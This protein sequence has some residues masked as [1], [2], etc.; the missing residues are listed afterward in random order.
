MFEEDRLLLGIR[1]LDVRMRIKKPLA[2]ILQHYGAKEIEGILDK[3]S[4]FTFAPIHMLVT[5]S[6]FYSPPPFL[7][8][9]NNIFRRSFQSEK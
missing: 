8:I 6:K 3:V 5:K 9:K 2:F 4:N 1:V 7:I